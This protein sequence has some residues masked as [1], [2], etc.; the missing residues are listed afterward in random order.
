MTSCRPIL[1]GQMVLGCSNEPNWQ[2]VLIDHDAGHE[3]LQ[4]RLLPKLLGVVS[5]AARKAIWG[6]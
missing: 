5:E 1:G 6:A 4:W 3:E 2:V